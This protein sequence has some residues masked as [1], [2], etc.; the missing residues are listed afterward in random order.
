MANPALPDEERQDLVRRLMAARCA[1][2]AAKRAGDQAA[3]VAARAE[4]DLAKRALGER[5]PVWWQDGTPD[6]NRAKA[7]STTYAAWYDRIREPAEN[8][9]QSDDHRSERRP[10][11]APG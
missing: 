7:K 11:R 3:E 4:V 2:G 10:R 9:T 1:V 6:L 5:G 8:G